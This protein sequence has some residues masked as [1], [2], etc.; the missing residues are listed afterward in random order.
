M[1]VGPVDYAAM[2]QLRRVLASR[3]ESTVSDTATPSTKG[4][5]RSPSLAAL[6]SFVW[7]GLGQLYLRKRRLAAIAEVKLPQ[8]WPHER[9]QGGQRWR[10]F[11]ALRRRSGG[12]RYGR[13]HSRGENA[14]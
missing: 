9:E 3:M 2:Q 7:P 8:T 13:L 11:T 1:L 4:G 5:E 14:S 12:I 6:L 10:P